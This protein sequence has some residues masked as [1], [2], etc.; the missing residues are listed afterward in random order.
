MLLLM[1]LFT[2][3]LPLQFSPLVQRLRGERATSVTSMLIFI[4]ATIVKK[5]T[6]TLNI[7]RMYMTHTTCSRDGLLLARGL[8]IY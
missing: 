2:R 7:C 4:K 6:I 1:M 3:L 5:E 8:I